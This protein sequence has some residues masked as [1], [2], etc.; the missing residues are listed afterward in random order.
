V[1]RRST[2]GLIPV[3]IIVLALAFRRLGS[4]LNAMILRRSSS[5]DPRFVLGS[6]LAFALPLGA[7]LAASAQE[8][9]GPPTTAPVPYAPLPYIQLP[10]TAPGGQV[11]SPSVVPAPG[12]PPKTEL[13][14][15]QQHDQELDAARAQQRQAAETQ[16]KLKREIEAIG[17]DRRDLNQHLIDTATRVRDVEA[18]I[19]ATES[20][21]NELD[22]RDQVFRASLDARR[23]V[24]IEILTALQR[25]GRQSPPALM[26]QPEDALQ[27]V[28]TAITL[29][30]VVPEMRAQADALAGELTDLLAVRNDIAGAREQ[31]AQELEVLAREQLR[32]NML[33]D[34]RQ[35]KQAAAEQALDSERL[36][37]ADLARQVD[38]LKELIARL[39]AGLDPAA[40]AA[41]L[42]ARAIEGDATRPDLAALRDPGRLTPAVAFAANRGHLRLPVN[43]VRIREFGG[44]DG[45]G[46]TQ[47][48]LSIAT[49]A[50]AE[51]TAPCDGWVV[52]AGPFRS[53]G[54]LLILNA[55]GGYHV[56]LAGMERISVDLGQ[57]V[58]T[59]EPVAEMGSGSQVSAAVASGTRQ[60]VLY[61]EF[62]KDGAPIDPSPWWATN[63]SEKVRG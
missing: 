31:R 43:G 40:R 32:L 4:T 14:A 63:E 27:A 51:I 50:G 26:V 60:P 45:V 30:A 19:D 10:A 53:Y 11:L 18:N 38:S 58:L 23:G 15:L 39:E 61:V 34:E 56:L 16:A 28:R 37:A 44:S 3:A 24:I 6:A 12:V 21:L 7:S 29:G 42:D 13:N 17:E 36:R 25:I 22:R 2:L 54:Q 35:K 9:S 8:T 46:G 33:I 1:T 62:R 20:R 5:T 49:H 59:G 57:F 48:G 52:Y 41:R 47:K 55:G